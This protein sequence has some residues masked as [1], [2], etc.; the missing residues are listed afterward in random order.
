MISKFYKVKKLMS[1]TS[2]QIHLGRMTISFGQN[3]IV[4]WAELHRHLGRIT[5]SFGQN[6][7]HHLPSA[8]LLLPSYFCHLPSYILHLTSSILHLPSYFFHPMC[9]PVPASLGY[10]QFSGLIN[11]CPLGRVTSSGNID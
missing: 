9:Q 1:A 11:L 7:I 2:A 6:Y 8:I 10:F 5:T 4:I 3:Y